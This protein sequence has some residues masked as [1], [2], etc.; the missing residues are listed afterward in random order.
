MYGLSISLWAMYTRIRNNS[1]RKITSILIRNNYV[2]DPGVQLFWFCDAVWLNEM[3]LTARCFLYNVHPMTAVRCIV[4]FVRPSGVSWEPLAA[5]TYMHTN[6][7]LY[8]MK[9][10]IVAGVLLK[11]RT[12]LPAPICRC[13]EFVKQCF[14]SHRGQGRGLGQMP[15][16]QLRI[17]SA[18]LCNCNLALHPSRVA[19]SSTI[20]G[21][22]KGGKVTASGWQVTVW[23]HM[24]CDFP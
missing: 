23:S 21:W 2:T 19:K 13:F 14:V 4:W 12:L 7:M 10:R 3:S 6:I 20:F 24:A 15:P 18:Q 11:N 1:V 5:P 9:D 8:F 17:A 22:G 16:P